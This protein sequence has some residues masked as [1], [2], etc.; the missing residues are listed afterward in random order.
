M[1]NFKKL[2]LGA[3][4]VLTIAA[5]ISGCGSEEKKADAA[6]TGKV[7]RVGTEATYPPFE[8]TE[9]DS[10]KVQ[11]FD[12]DIMEAVAKRMGY[13]VKWNNMGFDGLIPAVQSGQIDAVIASMNV[14]P[15]REKAVS[16]STPYYETASVVI[17]LK[18]DDYDSMKSIEGKTIAVQIGTEQVEEAKKVPNAKVKEFNLVPDILN[19]LKVGGS[20]VAIVDGPLAAFYTK[21]DPNTFAAFATG[22]QPQ[23]IAIAVKKD[24]KELQGKINKALE[25]MKK[26]GEYQKIV[27]KWFGGLKVSE[28][29]K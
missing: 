27:N 6:D 25:D 21:K 24:N 4:S 2:L 3:I 10:T 13:T 19:E 23:P 5:M 7:L 29:K 8:F 14:T 20:Q 15:D 22:H 28:E 26:D 9:N 12:V 18:K 1:K 11:G 16:F 17:H